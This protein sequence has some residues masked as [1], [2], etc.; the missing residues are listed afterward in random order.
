MS[1]P[2]QNID[3]D[4][5]IRVG[6]SG[7][8]FVPTVTIAVE[9]GSACS[10]SLD[11]HAEDAW[12]FAWKVIEAAEINSPELIGALTEDLHALAKHQAEMDAGTLSDPVARQILA[13]DTTDDDWVEVEQP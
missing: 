11:M 1:Y 6:N 7:Y 10:V 9:C 8:P 2:Y 4:A 5:S 3:H 12:H 13:G